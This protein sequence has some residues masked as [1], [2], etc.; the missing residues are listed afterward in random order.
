MEQAGRGVR[1]KGTDVA[2]VVVAL[3]GEEDSNVDTFRHHVNKIAILQ[4]IECKIKM[5]IVNK[6]NMSTQ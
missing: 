1:G 5:I 4:K 3:V 6:Q 2:V